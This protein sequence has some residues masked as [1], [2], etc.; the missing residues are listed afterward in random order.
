MK[1]GFAVIVMLAAL[2][3]SESAPDSVAPDF[4][5]IEDVEGS[6]SSDVGELD[7]YLNGADDS[8][9]SQGWVAIASIAR[10]ARQETAV[11]VHNNEV[12][13]LGG[14][15]D[16][17]T[18]LATVEIY[19]PESGTWRAGPQLPVAMHHAN[20]TVVNGS[21]WILGFLVGGFNADGRI[22]EMVNDAWVPRGTMPVERTRGASVLGVDGTKAY[23]VGGLDGGAV[24]CFDR[25]DTASGEW[26]T[27]PDLPAVM[28][29]GAGAFLGGSM[30]VAGG[31]AGTLQSHTDALHV[32]DFAE[33]VW[34]PG[35]Q[36]PTSRAG[37]AYAVHEGRLFVIGGEGNRAEA[38]GVF[39]EVESY[40]PAMDVWQNHPNMPRPRHGMG[41]ASVEGVILV[42]GGAEVQAFGATDF[43]DGFI[44]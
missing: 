11:F 3:C 32:F 33:N 8:G 13:V 37:F 39:G 10:G 42:P 20:A 4:G 21:V 27:L 28:D 34:K 17:A 38:S 30:V 18:M 9:M 26:Q 24:S 2:G 31:R 14:F 1:S 15:D 41:A 25:Y 23:V 36:M 5:M 22:F 43:V 19:N 35:A 44:P 40:D 7:A 12:W 29:H 16:R 6:D